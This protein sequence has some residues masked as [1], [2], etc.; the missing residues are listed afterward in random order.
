VLD[1][2]RHRELVQTERNGHADKEQ[3]HKNALDKRA[4]AK[5]AGGAQVADGQ[6]DHQ[7]NGHAKEHSTYQ[8]AD[9]S[10]PQ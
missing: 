6:D 9:L 8:I 2:V 3:V 7:K 1:L 5:Q 4:K 10:A